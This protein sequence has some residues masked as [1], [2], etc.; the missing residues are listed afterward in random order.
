MTLLFSHL[1]SLRSHLYY[2]VVRLPDVLVDGDGADAV[3]HDMP[4]GRI[5]DVL[6]MPAD[7][8]LDGGVFEHTVAGR[9]EGAVLQLQ[10]MG[11]A[12]QLFAC[13][14]AVDEPHMLGVPR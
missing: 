12:E 2:A 11:V 4:A 10:M 7:V 14:V 3:S 6:D 8:G 13:E 9:V 5:F 1:S